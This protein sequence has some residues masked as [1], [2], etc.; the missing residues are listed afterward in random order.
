MKSPF[1]AHRAYKRRGIQAKLDNTPGNASKRFIPR[2]PLLVQLGDLLI[3]TGL[4]LKRNRV[5]HKSMV[6]S[7]TTGVKP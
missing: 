1:N 2:E 4:K 5:S 6:W 7:P 3:H